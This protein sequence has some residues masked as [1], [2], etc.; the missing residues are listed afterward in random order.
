MKDDLQL[1][2]EIKKQRRA[3]S[4]NYNLRLIKESGIPYSSPCPGTLTFRKGVSVDFYLPSGKWKHN[5]TPVKWFHGGAQSFINWYRK[6]EQ[7]TLQAMPLPSIQ[8][9]NDD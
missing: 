5:T 9:G 3:D 7:T 6:H 2:K 8:S 1:L 4:A